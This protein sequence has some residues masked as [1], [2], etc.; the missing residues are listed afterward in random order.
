M[1]PQERSLWNE[2]MIQRYQPSK[3]SHPS[4]IVRWLEER[5]LQ[6]LLSWL[7]ISPGDRV[8]DAGCGNGELLERMQAGRLFGVD[9]SPGL[10][11]EARRRLG[12]RVTIV[13]GDIERHMPFEPASFDK[14]CCTEV[15]EHLQDPH[16]ALIAFFEL[17]VPGGTLAVSVPNEVLINHLKRF[18]HIMHLF[19]RLLGTAVAQRMEQEW[20][21][22]VF[23]KSECERLLRDA[24]FRLDRVRGSPF[25][26][27]PI[28]YL[29]LA[30][31]P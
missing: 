19:H 6:A 11:A 1:S 10:V 29:F 30:R 16:H 12:M 20:H 21:L 25:P 26:W 2:R 15:L 28:R 31:R 24:G 18:L 23:R 7:A 4:R 13:E 14:I 8:L 3:T 9:L 27:L 17:L 22:Q 5:R